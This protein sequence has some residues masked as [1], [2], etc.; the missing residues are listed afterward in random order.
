[1]DAGK[2]LAAIG[3]DDVSRRSSSVSRVDAHTRFR[4][5]AGVAFGIE[6]EE[7][8]GSS[9]VRIVCAARL[10]ERISYCA[11]AR[12]LTPV[13]MWIGQRAVTDRFAAEDAAKGTAAGEDDVLDLLGV[14]EE[15]GLVAAG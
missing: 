11:V 7:D 1:M 14:L 13:L 15:A 2:C 6:G 3:P 4:R 5:R 12:E 8:D 10:G 9:R